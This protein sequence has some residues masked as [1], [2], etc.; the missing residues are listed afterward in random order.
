MIPRRAFTL[1][2]LLVSIAIIALLIALLLPAIQQTRELAR[3]TQCSNNLKQI[4]LS[5]SN[6]E[7]ALRVFPFG[8]LGVHGTATS[9]NPLHTWHSQIL[10]YLEQQSLYSAYQYNRTF[11]SSVNQQIAITTISTFICP[12]HPESAPVSGLWGQN[13]Y[14]GNAGTQSGINDGLLYPMSAVRR[15]D[16]T[17]GTSHTLAVGEIGYDLGGWARGAL[18]GGGGGGGGGGGQGFARAVVRWWKAQPNCA[19]PGF[20]PPITNC[21]NGVE[22][23]LQFSSFHSGGIHALI[24]DGRVTF[25]NDNMDL[26]LQRAIGTRYGGEVVDIP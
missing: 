5:L 2:E 7:S 4:G 3:R 14:A 11:N 18:A 6:Y 9:A 12:T 1:I 23:S 15:R 20:N 21:N 10:P 13:H 25:F 8:V 16:I 22:R 26:Q 19:K 24:C 17:D